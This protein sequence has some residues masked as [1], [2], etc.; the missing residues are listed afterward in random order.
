MLRRGARRAAATR[1]APYLSRG[2][3]GRA[4]S[5]SAPAHP[6]S[7]QHLTARSRPLDVVSCMRTDR[8]SYGSVTRKDSPGRPAGTRS[9]EKP[10][11]RCGDLLL[12]APTS[13]GVNYTEKYATT[14][15]YAR[16][17]ELLVSRACC[18]ERPLFGIISNT[19]V[20]SI[21]HG[22]ERG[23]PDGCGLGRGPGRRYRLRGAARERFESLLRN[24]DVIIHI[25]TSHS[26]L[27]PNRARAP[28]AAL[29]AQ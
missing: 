2:A 29:S 25:Y 21:L 1:R 12:C 24:S 4:G 5:P 3:A 9:G 16:A 20:R 15:S 11:G 6:Y 10:A 19:L 13:P 8:E 26:P 22:S 28:P 17:S 27:G 7:C 14:W 18:P 23:R